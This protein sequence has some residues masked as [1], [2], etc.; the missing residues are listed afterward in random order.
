MYTRDLR[1]GRCVLELMSM[2][3]IMWI[4]FCWI[5]GCVD[6]TISSNDYLNH[7]NE[8][9]PKQADVR[10]LSSDVRLRYPEEIEMYVK[11]MNL[12][13]DAAYDVKATLNVTAHDTSF[14]GAIVIHFR[15]GGRIGP[16]ELEKS[17]LAMPFTSDMGLHDAS[18]VTY[19]PIKLTWV[20]K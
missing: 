15:N 1:L 4:C 18:D 14:I 20:A 6:N 7:P 8:P 11:I 16:M 9:P 12:G 3:A 17:T 19:E 2:K 13:P 10:I 5:V